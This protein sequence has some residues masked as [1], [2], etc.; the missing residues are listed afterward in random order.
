MRNKINMS[1]VKKEKSTKKLGE[2]LRKK[3]ERDWMSG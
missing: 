3:K 2:K 1:E